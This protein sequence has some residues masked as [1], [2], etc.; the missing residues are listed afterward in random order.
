MIKRGTRDKIGAFE[1][2]KALVGAL[3]LSILIFLTGL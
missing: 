3:L 1:K 2:I